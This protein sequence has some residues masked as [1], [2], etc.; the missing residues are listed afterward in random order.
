MGLL[1][2]CKRKRAQPAPDVTEATTAE[3]SEPS[4]LVVAFVYGGAM[5]DD[6]FNAAHRVGQE[7]VARMSG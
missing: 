6:G 3:P 1:P 4:G 5:D 2:G 7:A